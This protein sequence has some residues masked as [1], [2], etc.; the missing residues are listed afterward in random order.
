MVLTA[1]AQRVM[2]GGMTARGSLTRPSL[3][4]STAARMFEPSVAI[5]AVDAIADGPSTVSLSILGV[6]AR[7]PVLSIATAAA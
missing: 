5:A 4:R 1:A 6:S 7:N 2:A 3:M